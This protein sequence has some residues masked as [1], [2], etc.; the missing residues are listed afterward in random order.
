MVLLFKDNTVNIFVCNLQEFR[1][2]SA[3]TPYHTVFHLKNAAMLTISV[4]LCVY[5]KLKYNRVIP[6]HRELISPL[7]I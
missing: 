1:L 2:A 3:S 6:C 7:I 4:H 5:L